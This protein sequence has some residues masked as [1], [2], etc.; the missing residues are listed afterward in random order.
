MIY[1]ARPYWFFVF[2]AVFFIIFYRYFWKKG[3]GGAII[4]SNFGDAKITKVHWKILIPDVMRIFGLIL[5]IFA[6]A[7]P[8]LHNQKHEID[9]EGIDIILVLDISSSMRAEDFKPNRLEAAKDVAEDFIQTRVSDQIGLVTFAGYS[10]LQAPLTV[11]YPFLLDYLSLV[12]IAEKDYDGTAIGMAIASSVNRL[13]KSEAKSKVMILLSDGRNNK[14]ELD[15]LTS[16]EMAAKY[17]IKIYTIGAGGHGK[18][19]YPVTD[20]FGRKTFQYVEADI[21]EETLTKVS[22]M[23]GAKY[24]RATDKENLR[25]IYDEISQLEKSKIEITEYTIIEEIYWWFLLPALGLVGLEFIWRRSKMRLM[26]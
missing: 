1:F 15:P 20:L 4:F 14:G 24:F 5:V 17:G 13:R 25:K 11:D 2:I 8:Q 21:D 6:L 9:T 10:F 22:E 23:T 7:R 18:A 3:S 12:E 26:N 19:P 16:A